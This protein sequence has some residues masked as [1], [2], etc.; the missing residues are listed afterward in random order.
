[1]KSIFQKQKLTYNRN[2]T[3]MYKYFICTYLC[4]II[5]TIIEIKEKYLPHTLITKSQLKSIA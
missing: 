5:C 2:K 4:K 3:K 1:M